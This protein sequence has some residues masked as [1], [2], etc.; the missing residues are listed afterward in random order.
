MRSGA[1]PNAGNRVRP[2]AGIL[3]W[4]AGCAARGGCSDLGS[5]H[6]PLRSA[7]PAEG[8][9]GDGPAPDRVP[10]TRRTTEYEYGDEYVPPGITR[11]DTPRKRRIPPDNSIKTNN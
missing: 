8:D 6:T 5:S 10:K 3:P 11:G 1:I 4:R 9:T 2:V 7:P